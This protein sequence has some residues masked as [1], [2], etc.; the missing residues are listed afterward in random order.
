MN[1][2]SGFHAVETVNIP[3]VNPTQQTGETTPITQLPDFYALLNHMLERKL[4]TAIVSKQK[5]QYSILSFKEYNSEWMLC[6]VENL[7]GIAGDD[8][9]I[10]VQKQTPIVLYNSAPTKSPFN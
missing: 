6:E 8:L 3:S 9:V 1:D 4:V 10:C 7:A 5:I 2:A